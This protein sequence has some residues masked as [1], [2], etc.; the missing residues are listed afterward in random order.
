MND[1]ADD[2]MAEFKWERSH[3]APE[4]DHFRDCS[5]WNTRATG[6][7]ARNQPYSLK[8]VMSVLK[9]APRKE[10]KTEPMGKRLR[11]L[12]EPKRGSLPEHKRH[13]T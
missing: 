8:N 13:H 3:R 1:S 4:Q 2:E 11:K 5:P 10:G 9:N 6:Q 7:L 12:S